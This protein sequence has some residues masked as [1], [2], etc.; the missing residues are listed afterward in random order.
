MSIDEEA[1]VLGIAAF[2][3]EFKFHF[4]K[5]KLTETAINCERYCIMKETYCMV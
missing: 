2:T 5:R 4:T 3:C 1:E